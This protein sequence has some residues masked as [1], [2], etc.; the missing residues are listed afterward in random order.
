MSPLLQAEEVTEELLDDA[1]QQAFNKL[2]ERAPTE[3]ELE[4]YGQFLEL[5]IA[6]AD[7][8]RG[9]QNLLVAILVSGEFVFRMELG[10]GEELEDGRRM[11]SPRE[12]AYAISYAITDRAPDSDLRRAVTAG[13]LSTRDDAERE[14][15]RL[16]DT[17]DDRRFWSYPMYH[18]WESTKNQHNPRLLRFFQEFFGYTAA[19]DVFKDEVHVAGRRHDPKRLARDADILILHILEQD[20]RVFEELLTTDRYI[21]SY[22]DP[23]RAQTLFDEVLADPNHRNRGWLDRLAAG[24]NPNP[25]GYSGQYIQ[26][27]NYDDHTWSWPIEQPFAQ[28]APRAGILTHPAWLIAWSGNFDTDPIRRGKWIRERLLADSVPELP[29][30]VDA[31]LPE[32][33]HRTMR[34]RLEVTHADV[35]WRCHRQMNPLGVA[36]EAYD[37]FGAY[38]EEIVLGDADTYERERRN[39]VE[40]VRRTEQEIAE[41]TDFESLQ[42]RRIAQLNQQLQNNQPP[43]RGIANYEERL[44]RY[45]EQRQR[46]I[47]Q[48]EHWQHRAIDDRDELIAARQRQLAELPVPVP[49]SKPVDDSGVLVGTGDPQLD[50]P[51]EDAVDL[52]HRLAQSDRVRQSIIRHMFRYWLGR[53]EMLSDSPTLIAMDQAYLDS[54]GS[55]KETLVAL[56]TSDS[57]LYR[58]DKD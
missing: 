33:P 8:L 57:F 19:E 54:N 16:L 2:L 37:D 10:L 20:Q 27:Y 22:M 34:E 26:A 32:D 44:R 38:R 24:R 41:W 46:S 5:S 39:Y 50:G 3:E 25:V 35:C 51:Y 45:E 58:R 28:Q 23:E 17:P 7:N 43:E 9:Y 40:R 49:E 53:N 52:M 47:D 13:T 56:L 30:G 29:I 36:F 6:A 55:F 14:I 48:R 1:V 4:R 21:V 18:R 11:L 15:R 12:L 42:A 31:N